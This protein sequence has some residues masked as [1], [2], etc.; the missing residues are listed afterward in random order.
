[1]GR[2]FGR[3]HFECLAQ[4]D[5]WSSAPEVI[6]ARR[7]VVEEKLRPLHQ[8]VLSRFMKEYGLYPHWQR[9]NLTSI[10][11]PDRKANGGHVDYIR[12]G[13][14]KDHSLVTELARRT[15]LTRTAPFG[16]YT[17]S[18]FASITQLQMGLCE[19]NW[20]IGLYVDSQAW[21]EQRN[22]VEKL[23]VSHEREN[24]LGLLDEL[25]KAGYSL[26]IAVKDG[27]A[28]QYADAKAFTRALIDQVNDKELM[29]VV[30]FLRLLPDHE[31]N[32]ISAIKDF[33]LR[34]FLRLIPVYTFAAWHPISNHHLRTL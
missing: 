1:M 33:V 32:E 12:L 8:Q 19:T 2:Y 14:G 7:E 26:E 16:N 10:Y 20:W 29:S 15:C 13:Y 18:S 27:A 24:W 30:I 21:A 11:W 22:L 9:G 25:L 3:E 28:R 5:A 4:G 31:A 6:A 17:Q 34:E 23:K